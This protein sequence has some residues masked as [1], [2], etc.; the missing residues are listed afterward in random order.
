MERVLAVLSELSLVH[1][2]LSDSDKVSVADDSESVKTAAARDHPVI[3]Q[4]KPQTFRDYRSAFRAHLVPAFGERSLA[5][6]T[7][8]DLQRFVADKVNSGVS[9]RRV[10]DILI[11]LKTMFR[12]AVQWRYLAKSPAVELR[13]PKFDTPEM[14]FLTPEEAHRLLDA[15]D[16][17]WR[18]FLM[19]LLMTGARPGEAIAI[20][21]KDLDL[22][23]RTVS[24]RYTMDRGNLLPPKTDNARRRISMPPELVEALRE[25]SLVSPWNPQGLV[26]VQPVSAKPVDLANFRN[27]VYYPALDAAGLRRVRLYLYDIRHTY[28]AWMI[29]LSIEPLQLSKNLGHYDLGFTYKT[30]GHLMPVS[31]H[32]GATRLGAMFGGARQKRCAA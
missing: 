17:Y 29:S 14:D 16:P 7:L 30:Y 15:I 26:F 13:A 32:D 4:M 11:P 5:S 20:R 22:E 21:W 1:T 8:Q 28:A 31:G 24:V 12:C 10:A 18:T 6:I 19:F 9:P 3:R 27:R 23:R 25:H 2:S